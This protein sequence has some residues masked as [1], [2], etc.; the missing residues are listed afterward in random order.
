VVGLA[1]IVFQP[2]PQMAD[3]GSLPIYHLA[4]LEG[5]CFGDESS[6][7]LCRRGEPITEV[8]V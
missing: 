2:N 4:K 3:F 6:C 1:V 8:L 5:C 7:E